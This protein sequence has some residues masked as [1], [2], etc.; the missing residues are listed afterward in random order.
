M[1]IYSYNRVVSTGSDTDFPITFDY[2]STS[3]IK[4]F[5]D[6]EEKELT[7]D[8]TINTSTEKVV[9]NS[10]PTSGSVILIQRFTPKTKENFQSD[11]VDFTDGSILTE[12]DLDNAALGLLYIAQEAEDAGSET[13]LSLDLT[14]QNWDALYDGTSRR[15]K[16]MADPTHGADAVTKDYVDGL[17]LYD[18]PIVPQVYGPFT[19]TASQTDFTLDP[20]STSTDPKSFFVDIDGVMQRP[21]TDFTIQSSSLLR[22]NSGAAAGEVVT[23][24]NI[25]VTRDIMG[26]NPTVQ[27]SLTVSENLTVNQDAS[28]GDDLTVTDDATVGGDLTVTG[29]TDLNGTLEVEGTSTLTGNVSALGNLTLSGLLQTVG[30]GG[31][32]STS[33]IIRQIVTQ[34]FDLSACAVGETAFIMEG[35]STLG[36]ADRVYGMYVNI[37]PQSANSK[38]LLFAMPRGVMVATESGV[39]EIHA[40]YRLKVGNTSAA[41]EEATGTNVTGSLWQ[42]RLSQTHKVIGDSFTF[43]EGSNDSGTSDTATSVNATKKVTD[44][45]YNLQHSFAYGVAVAPDTMGG[46]GDNFDTENT[47][48]I[49]GHFHELDGP[50]GQL[51]HYFRPTMICLHNTTSTAALRFDVSVSLETT[52]TDVSAYLS[53][54]NSTFI[55]IEIG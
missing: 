31:V 36:D 29:N 23:I 49:E 15:I 34:D 5:V 39:D 6:G 42:E 19:A 9:F 27:G 33:T 52:T 24:R 50:S 38:I 30:A 3:H 45:A 41:G 35:S 44:S 2:L 53:Q 32:V 7:T 51:R 20:P 46:S 47:R 22:L 10:A 55:A 14:D 25:G 18:S 16:N 48:I 11:V 37:T 13:A 1:P 17:E 40:Q 12:K 4:V 54:G 8:Y 43:T 21:T 28:I 26:T